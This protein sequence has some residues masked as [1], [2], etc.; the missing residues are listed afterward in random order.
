V[1]GDV[2]EPVPDTARDQDKV[3]CPGDERPVPVG[4]VSAVYS[5]ASFTGKPARFRQ[6]DWAIYLD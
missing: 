1:E 4:V 5:P 6:D 3:T 2:L